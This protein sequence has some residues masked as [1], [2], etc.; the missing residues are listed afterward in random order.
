MYRSNLVAE[1]ISPFTGTAEEQQWPGEWWELEFSLPVMTR[2]QAA[3][4]IAFIN[5]LRG[6]LGTFL[7]GDPSCPAPQGS[8][9]GNPVAGA[10]NAAGS[11][12]LN[13][14]G[15]TPSQSG[16]LLPGDY[17]QVQAAG[18]PQ[19]LYQN[20]TLAGS[21]PGGNSALDIYPALRESLVAGTPIVLIRPAG[22]FRLTTNRDGFS[23]DYTN[24]FTI[25]LKAR[26][27][28]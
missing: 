21:G 22:T 7:M 10:P 25:D 17:V 20:L 28:L 3:P 1:N 18:A 12:V 19:R 15:W 13:S 14:S 23:V 26:E 24:L 9:P 16:I 8:A 11:I 6:K 27:A 2:A 5:A 4:W